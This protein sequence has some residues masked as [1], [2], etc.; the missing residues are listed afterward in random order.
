MISALYCVF[1]FNLVKRMRMNKEIFRFKGNSK[2]KFL[3]F[4]NPRQSS[5]LVRGERKSEKDMSYVRV[6]ARF[7]RLGE[8]NKVE[9]AQITGFTSS[10]N[11]ASQLTYVLRHKDAWKKDNSEVC[12]ILVEEFT[13][14]FPLRSD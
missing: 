4:S 5:F 10:A 3:K 11:G 13:R 1:N 12:S 7:H 2:A 9:I 6:G 8:N 14:L